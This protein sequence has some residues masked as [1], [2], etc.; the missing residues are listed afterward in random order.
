[1][2][3]AN[4]NMTSLVK[5]PLGVVG[6]YLDGHP[7]ADHWLKFAEAEL[8][9]ELTDWIA[10]GG[11]WIECPMYQTPSLDG[12]FLLA[13]AIKNVKG[14]DYFANPNFRATM[15]YCGFILT[16]PDLRFPSLKT[17]DIPAPMTVPSIGD[18]FPCFTHPFNGWMARVTAQS[19]PAYSARQQSYWKG[20]SFSCLNAGRGAAGFIAAICDPDLPATPPAELARSFEGFGNILRTSWTDPKATYVAHRNGYFSHHFDHGDGNSI[21]VHAKGVPLIVDFGHRGAT[22][23]EVVTMWK[24]MYHTTVS[25]DRAIPEGHWGMNGGP[26]EMNIK[27]QEVRSLPRTIDYSTGLSFGA[28]NQRNNRHLLLV[29]SDDQMG[30]NYVVIRDITQ[31]GQPNQQFTWN[32]WCMAKEPQISG[33]VAHFP[34]Q[35]GVDL[36]AHVLTPASP[37][38]TKDHYK[39]KQW[40]NP[41]GDFIE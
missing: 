10:P 16:P 37:Q 26:I 23:D 5:L 24:P 11:A 32:V 17:A 1:L 30:A 3:S 12:M 6:L 13:Q 8:N 21:L 29:K 35:F 25:F 27:A 4:P 34:G 15:D 18:A 9:V 22:H 28:G 33:N 19:D 41:W 7:R 14:K 20:Q 38:F 2:Q 40:V 36:D 39:Y 31:D